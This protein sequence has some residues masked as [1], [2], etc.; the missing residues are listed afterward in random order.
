M[1]EN[2]IILKIP[3]VLLPQNDLYRGENKIKSAYR[4]FLQFFQ[5][6]GRTLGHL[7]SIRFVSPV[8]RRQP[9]PSKSCSPVQ[10]RAR[11]LSAPASCL[12]RPCFL[13]AFGQTT[14]GKSSR[15]VTSCWHRVTLGGEGA[16][17]QRPAPRAG[18][19]GLL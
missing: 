14:D 16:D 18:N 11:P 6:L 3:G 10:A 8:A 19:E 1:E 4:G 9:S 5:N 12:L 13:P 2:Q 15:K 17:G 7:S